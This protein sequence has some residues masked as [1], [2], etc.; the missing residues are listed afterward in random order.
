MIY[1]DNNATTKMHKS[2][3]EL[4]HDLSRVPLNPSSVHYAGRHARHIIELARVQIKEL[5]GIDGYSKDHVVV[6]TAT[7]TEA[8]NLLLSNFV[9]GDI[10]VSSIEHMSILGPASEHLSMNMI[11]VDSD[12]IIDI[13]HLEELLSNSK[14]PKKLISVMLVNNETGVIEPLKE[15][16]RI[17]K[18]FGA[19]VHSD[20]AAAVGKISV[21]MIDMGVDFITVSGHKFGG[22]IGAAAIITNAKYNLMP[23]IIGGGQEH[24]MRAGTENTVGIA[25]FGLAAKLAASELDQRSSQMLRMQQKL[26][27]KLHASFSNVVIFSSNAGRVPNTSLISI[28]NLDASV[29]LI[30]LDMHKI[31]VSTG[32]ACSSGKIAASHVLAAMKVDK[33]LAKSAIR[34][35]TSYDTS[36]DDIDSLLNAC[37]IYCNNL[38][39]S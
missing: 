4:M 24:G 35:S 29:Q 15:V 6:F 1:L 33:M 30:A 27:S 11:A 17:A 26:E 28:S 2:V 16:V 34:I 31:A 37:N 19:L 7:G 36:D 14:N 38:A 9:D 8:N 10:F 22:P 18:K 12:G 39:I 3:A 23:M 21:N 32:S 13:N 20:C 5:L 25:G